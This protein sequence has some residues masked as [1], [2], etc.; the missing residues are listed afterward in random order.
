MRGAGRAPDH[1]CHATATPFVR[2]LVAG[3]QK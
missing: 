2:L 3:V 1:G